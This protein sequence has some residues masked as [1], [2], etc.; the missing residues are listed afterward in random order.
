[1]A[2]PFLLKAKELEEARENVAK[3]RQKR[4]I[5]EKKN[6]PEEHPELTEEED[7]E[8]VVEEYR[9][10][11]HNPMSAIRAFCVECQGGYLGEVKRCT[12]SKENALAEGH[13]RWCPHWEF[14]MG[15]NPYHNRKSKNEGEDDE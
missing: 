9:E 12:R 14:R 1:M 4:L 11:V 2:G 6:P 7:K 3:E 13:K 15:N 5:K 8:R 10:K